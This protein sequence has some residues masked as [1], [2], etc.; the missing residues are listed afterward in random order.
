M[1]D[2]TTEWLEIHVNR[3]WDERLDRLTTGVRMT[4]AE[5]ANVMGAARDDLALSIRQHILTG[6]KPSE[7]K[8]AIQTFCD[9][10]F[11]LRD[12]DGSVAVRAKPVTS[13]EVERVERIL[14]RS[15]GLDGS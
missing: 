6:T 7:V 12:H 2:A 14:R 3:I 1:A 9:L 11:W 8:A 5:L 13:G 10:D 4:P 15:R